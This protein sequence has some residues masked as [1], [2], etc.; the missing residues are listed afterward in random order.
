[1]YIEGRLFKRSLNLGSR[2]RES[3]HFHI[4]FLVGYFKTA[5]AYLVYAICFHQKVH[6]K[7][8][9]QKGVR[10]Q[11]ENGLQRGFVK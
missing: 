10:R 8:C 9:L 11:T 6:D 2:F 7:L 3:L 1:M 5:N 4:S